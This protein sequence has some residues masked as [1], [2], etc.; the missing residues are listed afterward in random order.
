MFYS[1]AVK[2]GTRGPHASSA[3]PTPSWFS[4]GG[5]SPNTSCETLTPLF[6]RA[7]ATTEKACLLSLVR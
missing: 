6:Y 5:K 4:E 1:R 7:G 3:G 2:L